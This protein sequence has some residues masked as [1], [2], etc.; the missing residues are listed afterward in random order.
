[1]NTARCL[2]GRTCTLATKASSIVSRSTATAS[3]YSLL[4]AISS[5]NRSGYGW[6]RGTS[7]KKWITV[8]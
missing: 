6:S 2:G 1:M 5:N 4:G 3:G 8:G 7:E